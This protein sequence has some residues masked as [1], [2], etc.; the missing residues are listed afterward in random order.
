MQVRFTNFGKINLKVISQNLLKLV[1][2]SKSPLFPRL[3]SVRV[4]SVGFCLTILG[5][6]SERFWSRKV[7][8]QAVHKPVGECEQS[9]QVLK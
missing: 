2:S 8:V 3:L 4:E 9:K 5:L 1:A 7:V 6:R